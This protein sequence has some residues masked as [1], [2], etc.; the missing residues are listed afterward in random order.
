MIEFDDHIFQTSWNHQLDQDLFFWDEVYEVLYREF[1]P[2]EEP[3]K[4]K[5]AVWATK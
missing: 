4:N 3:L 5:A 2:T 1:G